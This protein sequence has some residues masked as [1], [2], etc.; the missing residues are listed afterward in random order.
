[1]RQISPELKLLDLTLKNASAIQS[2][3]MGEFTTAGTQEI[4][5]VRPGGAIEVYKIE[6]SD[7]P[8]DDQD[9]EEE[10]EEES[11]TWLKM[12]MRVE[13]R[14]VIRSMEIVRLA[15]EK[16]DLVIIGSDS[17]NVSVLDFQGGKAKILH[18]PTF[19]KTGK[20]IKWN[21]VD[22]FSWLQVEL[23]FLVGVDYSIWMISQ[24][25]L[26]SIS[27][28]VHRSFDLGSPRFIYSMLCHILFLTHSLTHSKLSTHHSLSHFVYI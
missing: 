17:G 28:H 19:G 5:L 7:T 27:F 12:I 20:W 3:T 6:S 21:Q 23:T 10:E 8:K 18:C 11:R 1:M 24:S 22:F 9:D 4:L 13:T 2:S 26:A 16:R 14:S 15:G 25:F